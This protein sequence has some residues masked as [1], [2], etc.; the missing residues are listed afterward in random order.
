MMEGK[1][2]EYL[3]ASIAVRQDFKCLSTSVPG[4][5]TPCVLLVEFS[6]KA[7]TKAPFASLFDSYRNVLKKYSS[8]L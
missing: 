7:Q 3:A 2:P 4:I 6:D 5:Y 1:K 8:S